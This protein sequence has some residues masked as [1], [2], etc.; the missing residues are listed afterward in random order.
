[1]KLSIIDK[2]PT[3]V[4]FSIPLQNKYVLSLIKKDDNS[5]EFITLFKIDVNISINEFTFKLMKIYESLQRNEIGSMTVLKLIKEHGI[6]TYNS[7]KELLDYIVN[8]RVKTFR[9]VGVNDLYNLYGDGVK[10]Y[11]FGLKLFKELLEKCSQNCYIDILEEHITLY[12]IL[13]Y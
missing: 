12:K 8:E 4:L 11:E 5:I 10:I 7:I 9:I 13:G 1:M 3:N 2:L 6:T